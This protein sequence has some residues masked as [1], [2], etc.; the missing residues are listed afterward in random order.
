MRLLVSVTRGGI[1]D[2]PQV[3]SFH[4]KSQVLEI[5]KYE[6]HFKVSHNE[7]FYKVEVLAKTYFSLTG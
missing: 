6:K 5:H 1:R 3:L 4:T 7:E 2:F